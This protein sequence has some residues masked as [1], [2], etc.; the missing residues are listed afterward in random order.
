M[1]LDAELATKLS[2]D[3]QSKGTNSDAKSGATS[4][5]SNRRIPVHG[6]TVSTPRPRI[7]QRSTL[8]RVMPPRVTPQRGTANARERQRSRNYPVATTSTTTSGWDQPDG[9]IEAY[10][11]DNGT[12][13]IPEELLP[14]FTVPGML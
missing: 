10:V 6:P 5:P 2:S 8:P 4:L 12:M 13:F 3:E 1:E 9:P 11:D 7:P 14:F